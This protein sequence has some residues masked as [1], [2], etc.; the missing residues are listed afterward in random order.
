MALL[1]TS[2]MY[3]SVNKRGNKFVF[4][5]ITTARTMW[6]INYSLEYA[7]MLSIGTQSVVVFHT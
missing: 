4:T 5:R 1:I 6:L 7:R 3:F 2:N